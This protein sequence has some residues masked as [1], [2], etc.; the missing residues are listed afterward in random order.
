MVSPGHGTPRQ[1]GDSMN[2]IDYL[3]ATD[4][5]LLAD[6]ERTCAA[7]GGSV[8]ALAS[9]TVNVT[10]KSTTNAGLCR[11]EML[12]T[13]DREQD[14][15]GWDLVAMGGAI[16]VN[17]ALTAE[18]AAQVLRHEIGHAIAEANCPGAGHGLP[19]REAAAALGYEGGQFATDD[20]CEAIR[21]GNLATGAEKVVARCSGGCGFEITRS[22]YGSKD[23]RRFGHECADGGFRRLENVGRQGPKV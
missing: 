20:E 5:Q 2:L 23:W 18:Q 15:D 9:W 19:W 8:D 16:M 1:R 3:A 11:F 17:R 21:Q 10:W 22:R 12:H 13:F 4:P 7:F 14:A 6:V